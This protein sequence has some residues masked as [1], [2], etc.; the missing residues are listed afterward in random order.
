MSGIRAPHPDAR[1][2][3]TCG[4]WRQRGVTHSC[5]GD[6]I[7]PRGVYRGRVRTAADLAPHAFAVVQV[8][9]RERTLGVAGRAPKARSA[10]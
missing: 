9:W 7:H 3:P 8:A 6:R 1:E 4:G 10:A 5:A 2:C